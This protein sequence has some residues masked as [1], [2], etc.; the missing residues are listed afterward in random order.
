MQG[1]PKGKTVLEQFGALRFKETTTDDY[2][3]VFQF[4][5]QAGIDLATYQY[6][7]D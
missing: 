3:P 7:N 2:A 4:A 1:D 6:L 5:A